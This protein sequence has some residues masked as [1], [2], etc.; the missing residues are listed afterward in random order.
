MVL[1]EPLTH[2]T[3]SK[4]AK[5][6]CTC[7]LGTCCLTKRNR[8]PCLCLFTSYIISACTFILS[9]FWFYLVFFLLVHI[10]Y[11]LLMSDDLS[12]VYTYFVEKVFHIA[13]AD[14]IKLTM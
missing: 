1:S 13:Q 9:Q 5:D 7:N 2:V 8:I 14:L 12:I 6:L 3:I 11:F 4:A 10:E